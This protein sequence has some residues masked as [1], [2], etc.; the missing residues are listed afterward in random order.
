MKHQESKLQRECVKWF[1][2]Q[3]PH[4][5]RLLFAV[6]N[7]GKRSAFEAAIMKAEGVVSGVSDLI[8]MVPNADYHAFCI[9]MKHG[10]NGLSENQ[11]DFKAAVEKRNY[12]FTICRSFD[13]FKGEVERYLNPAS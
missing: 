4:L 9:E 13:E 2:L 7:G 5:R 11:E 10:K 8:L 3:Y 6:P 12:K 1:R